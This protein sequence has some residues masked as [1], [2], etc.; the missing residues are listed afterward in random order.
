MLW[1]WESRQLRVRT[2]SHVCRSSI[3]GC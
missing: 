3:I 2:W 1:W